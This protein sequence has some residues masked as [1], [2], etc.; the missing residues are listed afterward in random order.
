[1]AAGRVT[2]LLIL[3]L[4]ASWI[5]FAQASQGGGIPDS[6]HETVSTGKGLL[7]GERVVTVATNKNLLGGRK[8]VVDRQM[9]VKDVRSGGEQTVSHSSDEVDESGFVAFNADYHAPRHHPPKN[10]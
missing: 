6:N 4:F 3:L 8:M 10:N 2:C 1:M 5:S 7:D 9:K